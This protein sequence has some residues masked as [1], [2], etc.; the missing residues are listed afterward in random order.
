M[1]DRDAGGGPEW[2][3][4]VVTSDKRQEAWSTGGGSTVGAAGSGA[5]KEAGCRDAVWTPPVQLG[6]LPG[7]YSLSSKF[8]VPPHVQKASF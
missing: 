3:T 4:A 1:E 2:G 7:P 8:S 5:Q 6:P